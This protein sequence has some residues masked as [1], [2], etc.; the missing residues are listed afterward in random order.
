MLTGESAVRHFWNR[1]RVGARESLQ[2][3]RHLHLIRLNR[4]FWAEGRDDV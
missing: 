3:R 1:I 2:R 4:L